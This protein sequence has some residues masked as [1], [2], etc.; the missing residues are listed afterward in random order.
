MAKNTTS[1]TKSKTFID[2]VEITSDT[3]TGR[4]GL[5][6]FVRYLRGIGLYPQLETFF[7]SIRRSRKGQPISEVFKQLFCFFMDGTS[8]HLVHF[9]ALC[10]DG[11]Y[12]G[13]I[14]SKPAAMLSSHGVKRFFRSFWWPCVTG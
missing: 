2:R 8:R 10:R 11:G 14:E 6:L 12:A 13:A 4:G 3:L 5:S 1:S 9:D 7:G